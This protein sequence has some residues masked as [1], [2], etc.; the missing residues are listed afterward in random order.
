M[1]SFTHPNISSINYIMLWIVQA[2]KSAQCASVQ[3]RRF[4]VAKSNSDRLEVPL[5]PVKLD[6][7]DQLRANQTAKPEERE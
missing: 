6:V 7:R 5:I 4:A 3:H 1:L 2:R